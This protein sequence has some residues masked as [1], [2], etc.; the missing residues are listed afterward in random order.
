[1]NGGPDPS[2]A[3][4]VR[5]VRRA[6]AQVPYACCS[7]GGWRRTGARRASKCLP[8]GLE[9]GTRISSCVAH[10]CGRRCARRTGGRR[11]RS[12]ERAGRAGVCHPCRHRLGVSGFGAVL[13]SDGTNSAA[14][15]HYNADGAPAGLNV[16]FTATATADGTVKVPYT[17]SGLHAWFNVTANLQKFVNGN[18]TSVFNAGPRAAARHRP[19]G[20]STAASRPSTSRPATPTV[21]SSAAT[22]AT[23]TASSAAR[24]R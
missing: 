21:S 10:S 20:S 17:W 24:S 1:M 13:D 15:M 18:V 11:R 12:A 16:R 19:T 7:W 3:V 5:T 9:R 22:T 14:T 4:G 2:E 23:S 6:I 8:G